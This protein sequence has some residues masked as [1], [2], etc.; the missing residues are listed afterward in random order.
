MT[1]N[2]L[3]MIMGLGAVS[4]KFGIKEI[5]DD[6]DCYFFTNFFDT[7]QRW[8]HL[9]SFS[10]FLSQLTGNTLKCSIWYCKWFMAKK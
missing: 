8:I 7:I 1:F 4:G 10:L 3:G 2:P 9:T 5:L 6:I